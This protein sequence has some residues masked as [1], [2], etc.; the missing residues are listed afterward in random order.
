[1]FKYLLNLSKSSKFKFNGIQYIVNEIVK[2]NNE[3]DTLV[4]VYFD[5]GKIEYL[6]RN[7]CMIILV[8]WDQYNQKFIILDPMT[9]QDYIHVSYKEKKN[10]ETFVMIKNEKELNENFTSNTKLDKIIVFHNI[11]ISGTNYYRISV[12][13]DKNGPK[14]ISIKQKIEEKDIFL[15]I[16]PIKADKFNYIASN[17]NYLLSV[18]LQL[19]EKSIKVNKLKI[20]FTFVGKNN[21]ICKQTNKFFFYFKKYR[22]ILNNDNDT[23]DVNYFDCKSIDKYQ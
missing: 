1:M 13:I 9:R 23:Y 2:I 8:F 15:K 14:D 20:N 6:I 7:D 22:I 10:V 5:K 3:N 21:K 17:N 12:I 18:N 16:T 4:S 19:E 11:K